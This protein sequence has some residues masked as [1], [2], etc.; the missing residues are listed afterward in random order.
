MRFREQAPFLEKL[1]VIIIDI[2]SVN[3]VAQCMALFG[4]NRLVFV[5][6]IEGGSG[7]VLAHQYSRIDAIG[8]EPLRLALE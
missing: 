1:V 3:P 2:C 8:K 7:F 4:M 6:V 5:E